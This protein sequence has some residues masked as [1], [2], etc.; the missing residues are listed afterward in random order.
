VN[1]SGVL[2]SPAAI[3]TGFSADAAR[4]RSSSTASAKNGLS[5]TAPVVKVSVRQ[6]WLPSIAPAL[7]SGSSPA[8]PREDLPVPEPP[9]T[10]RKRC[11][12]SRSRA[13]SASTSCPRP[14]KIGASSLRN[15]RRPGYGEPDQGAGAGALTFTRIDAPEGKI[16]NQSQARFLKS[17]GDLKSFTLPRYDP[18]EFLVR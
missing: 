12:Y 7:S 2:V 10:T 4:S 11:P 14:K 8:R 9:T 3:S 13:T 18:S 17:V 5:P 16:P 15:G 1:C 6:S